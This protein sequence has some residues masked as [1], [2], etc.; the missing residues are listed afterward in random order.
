MKYPMLVTEQRIIPDSE[1]AGRFRGSPG[2]YVEYGPVGDA[3]MEVVYLSDGTVNPA[4]GVRG[5]LDGGAGPAAK[6]I[7]R[8]NRSRT[9]SARTRESCCSPGRR[10]SRFHAEEAA[11]GRPTSATPCESR[12]TSARDG[13]RRLAHATSIASQSPKTAPSIGK[14]QSGYELD[15]GRAGQH[16][17]P[18]ARASRRDRRRRSVPPG[19]GRAPYRTATHQL[20]PRRRIDAQRQ[21]RS[22]RD[23]LAVI[24]ENCIELVELWFGCVTLGAILVPINTGSKAAQL[25]HILRDS[26][27]KVVLSGPDH[28]PK[29]VELDRPDP[30]APYGRSAQPPCPIGTAFRS[31]RSAPVTPRLAPRRHRPS[32]IRP[33]FSTH[34]AQPDHPKASCAPTPSST[35][36]ASIP[37]AR[38]ASGATTCSTTACR[39]ST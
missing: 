21:R 4:R 24:A 25:A 37:R 12:T 26:E 20:E 16:P 29:L 27:P 30:F 5:G 31:P 14:Q 17:R 6:A 10:S 9:S 8:R 15:R 3:P 11:T 33:R 34:R 18:P 22:Q 23:R 13:S 2:A 1:G 39:C 32:I 28:L 38:S 19:E 36:G 7:P 35:G